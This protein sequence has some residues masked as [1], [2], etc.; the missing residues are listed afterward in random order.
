MA[1]QYWLIHAF[2]KP[3]PII[4]TSL[5]GWPF[6]NQTYLFPH[7]DMDTW[8]I[9]DSI[10]NHHHHGGIS[11]VHARRM[12]HETKV[13]PKLYMVCVGLTPC[14]TS[15]TG[16]S[17]VPSHPCR[18]LSIYLLFLWRTIS[19]QLNDLWPAQPNQACASPWWKAWGWVQPNLSRG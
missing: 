12:G 17:H 10:I 14:P 4:Y 15:E 16:Q 7:A 6:W 18:K 8:R 1:L 5:I 9:H 13:T 11:L 3:T 2:N 19:A